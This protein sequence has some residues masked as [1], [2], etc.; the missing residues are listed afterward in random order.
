MDNKPLDSGMD[1]TD[2]WAIGELASLARDCPAV[3]YID[4]GLTL[5]RLLAESGY[6]IIKG[7]T[8]KPNMS[9]AMPT[10]QELRDR[11]KANHRAEQSDG[12]KQAPAAEDNQP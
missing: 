5:T 3:D 6:L 7:E 11:R 2:A 10:K 9:S 8:R 4:S 12:S 1:N